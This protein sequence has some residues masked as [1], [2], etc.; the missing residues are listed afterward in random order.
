MSGTV[1]TQIQANVIFNLSNTYGGGGFI[2]HVRGI[3]EQPL[4]GGTISLERN[5][6]HTLTVT[7]SVTGS[8][9]IGIQVT[10]TAPGTPTINMFNNMIS[11]GNTQGTNLS[12]AGVR[13]DG[14]YVLSYH[15]SIRIMGTSGGGSDS[16]FAYLYNTSGNLF[17]SRNNIYYNERT[18]GT[19]LHLAI[20]TVNAPFSYQASNNLFYTV[21][22]P[23]A[24]WTNI[25]CATLANW[26]AFSAQDPAPASK[27]SAMVFASA[28]DLHT[29]DLVVRNAGLS[30]LS[31]VVTLDIDNTTRPSCVDI[32]C[33]E[34]DVATIVGNTWT[35]LGSQSNLWCN[36][37]NWDRETV[38][39]ATS[40]VL[41]L[42]NRPRYP[43]LQAGVGCGNVTVNHFTV[44][45]NASSALSGQMDVGTYTLTINGNA[46][47]AG[48][49]LCTGATALSGITSG[50]I[51]IASTTQVQIVDIRNSNGVFPGTICKLRI[52]KTAPTAVPSTVH[53]A[54]LRGNLIILYNF[55]IANGVLLSKTGAT[56]DAD[57][58]TAVNYKT[59]TIVS[60]EPGAVTRQ[61][62]PAQETRNG[63]F[64]GRLNR[65]I[66]NTGA[67]N[68]YLFPLGYRSSGGTGVLADYFYTPAMMKNNSITN[69][70][71][72]VGTYLNNNSNGTVD[73][74]NIGFTGHGCMNAFEIDDIG[75]PTAVTCNNKEIDIVSTFYW[76]FQE[77]TG[78]AANGDPV[79]SA[80]ALGAINY[81]LQIAG[82]VFNLQNLDGLTGSELRVIRRP[83]VVIPG[84]AGQ[85]PFVSSAGTHSGIDISANTGIAM[86][87]IN[88]ASLQGARR[89]GLTTPGGMASAGNGPSP[90]PVELIHFSAAKSGKE[91]VVCEWTTAGEI[92]N[93]RF[94]VEAARE[95]D[96]LIVFEKIGV[97]AGAGT[98]SE[99]RDYS[100]TDNSPLSGRNYY[101]LKQID[102]DGS[103]RYSQTVIVYFSKNKNFGLTGVYPNPFSTQ[104]TVSI[105]SAFETRMQI[106]LENSL[107][108]ILF[109]DEQIVQNGEQSLQIYFPQDLS[110]G[111]YF[112]RL[113]HEDESQVIRMIKQ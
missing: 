69:N 11:I 56:Y 53:E 14:A 8:S 78:A 5:R 18:G 21:A 29:T 91:Q 26:S 97:I 80:G 98:I 85:G 39:V 112:M 41:I 9:A 60:D 82:D 73:G 89:N 113:M 27:Q 47:I 33:D 61:S 10:N 7:S 103:S 96:G 62:I 20:R 110:A 4:S 45:Q 40:D 3:F 35:W 2:L 24:M 15:N 31:P 101:R 86:Y 83:S 50:L 90:L 81:D 79:I 99:N 111:V 92:N 84:N 25:S 54:H 108:Q 1:G 88:A 44:Q 22:A 30:P 17:R 6:V 23:L 66:K 65:R 87:S 32:G 13:Q 75:G 42:D 74:V 95:K 49:C 37:C 55:D 38:P 16:S 67:G 109:S 63:F 52:N 36:S 51:D 107:G 43:L 70:Q 46:T 34:F 58:N 106:S 76:D 64:Q 12:I 19:G 105:Y 68:E 102:F 71:Y 94:E 28:T 77:N 57:E 104:A 72:M 100:F 93:D 59:I 48:T